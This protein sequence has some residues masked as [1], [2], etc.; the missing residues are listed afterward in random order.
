MPTDRKSGMY[1]GHADATASLAYLESIGESPLAKVA[2]VVDEL[3]ALLSEIA[4]RL[5]K[6]E[7]AK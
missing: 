6:L 2:A 3:A 7:A 4:D 5:D 1:F